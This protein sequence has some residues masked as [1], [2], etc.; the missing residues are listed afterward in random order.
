MLLELRGLRKG[1]VNMEECHILGLEGCPG[2]QCVC[3]LTAAHLSTT[4]DR[5]SGVAGARLGGGVTLRAKHQVTYQ[6]QFIETRFRHLLLSDR[7]ALLLLMHSPSCSPVTVLTYATCH[8]D[9]RWLHWRMTKYIFPADL[10]CHSHYLCFNCTCHNLCG[11]LSVQ[12]ACLVYS[13]FLYMSAESRR[14]GARIPDRMTSHGFYCE[15]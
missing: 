7:F 2:S 15:K 14:T 5:G 10:V 8:F 9:Y 1:W 11:K 13:H 4:C 3:P 6:L 12:S